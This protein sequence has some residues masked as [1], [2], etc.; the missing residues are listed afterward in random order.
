MAE[1]FQLLKNRNR[2]TAN[3]IC[4]EAICVYIAITLSSFI[5]MGWNLVFRFSVSTIVYVS[6]W[7]WLAI[8]KLIYFN[9]YIG[10]C[11]LFNDLS[12]LYLRWFFANSSWST[13]NFPLKFAVPLPA[14]I[15]H[16]LKKN[17]LGGHFESV[18]NDVRV[19]SCSADLDQQ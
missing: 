18:I 19:T 6:R 10:I 8:P 1:P 5:R 2:S 14:T 4:P 3:S 11:P 17:Q 9:Q 7:I 16:M 15:L 12:S 13:G